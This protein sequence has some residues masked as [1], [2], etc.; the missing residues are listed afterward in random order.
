MR[1]QG[2]R[3]DRDQEMSIMWITTFCVT[4]MFSFNCAESI[5]LTNIGN[6]I[7]EEIKG[8]S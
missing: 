4:Y 2:S 5:T 1:V 8:K 3:W 6:A 7:D